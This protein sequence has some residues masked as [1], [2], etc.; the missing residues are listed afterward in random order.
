MRVI[1]ARPVKQRMPSI[2]GMLDRE[3]QVV[4]LFAERGQRGGPCED[5]PCRNRVPNVS[6]T[7]YLAPSSSTIRI[8]AAVRQLCVSSF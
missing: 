8:R 5:R 7:P 4:I 2:S 6:H 1:P 3:Q